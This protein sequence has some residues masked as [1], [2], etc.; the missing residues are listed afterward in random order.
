M[1]EVLKHWEVLEIIIKESNILTD[2]PGYNP[3]HVKVLVTEL[4]FGKKELNTDRPIENT[5]IETILQYEETL[6]NLTSKKKIQNLLKVIETS[7][8]N[9]DGKGKFICVTQVEKF[10][11]VVLCLVC[12]RVSE[13]FVDVW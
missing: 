6:R 8:L 5:F 3:W 13:V 9:V 11:T 2:H 1:S 7:N 12:C 10:I 4:I